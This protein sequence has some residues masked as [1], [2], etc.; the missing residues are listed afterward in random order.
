MQSLISDRMMQDALQP[1]LSA[2]DYQNCLA[3][4]ALHSPWLGSLLFSKCYF[5]FHAN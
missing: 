4:S 3:A 2:C 5:P 1:A